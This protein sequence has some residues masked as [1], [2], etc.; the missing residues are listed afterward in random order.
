MLWWKKE[1]PPSKC[2][3]LSRLNGTPA[4]S[5]SPISKGTLAAYTFSEHF[6]RALG[7][8][9]SPQPAT[10]E[11]WSWG[12]L[13]K[14][15]SP[16][17]VD[18]LVPALKLEKA[19]LQREEKS[20]LLLKTSV[21]SSFPNLFV[22]FYCESTETRDITVL[23]SFCHKRGLSPEQVSVLSEILYFSSLAPMSHARVCLFVCF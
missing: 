17:M 12:L 11:R 2:R 10:A 4:V 14:S 20:V 1:D 6:S 15:I 18:L 9:K 13:G 19:S 16:V 5:F 8:V 23:F 7:N 22:I 21:W 3:A